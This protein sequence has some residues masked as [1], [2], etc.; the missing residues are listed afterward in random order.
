MAP[1]KDADPSNA[2]LA[3]RLRKAARRRDSAH[4]EAIKEHN[5]RSVLSSLTRW[6][7]R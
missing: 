2:S 5:R 3:E 6:A 7:R 4:A 1:R